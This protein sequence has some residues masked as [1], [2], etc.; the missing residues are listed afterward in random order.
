MCT[1]KSLYM[2]YCKCVFFICVHMSIYCIYLLVVKDQE[3]N[4][5]DYVQLKTQSG[6]LLSMNLLSGTGEEKRWCHQKWA[7]TAQLVSSLR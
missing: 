2:S 5:S 6:S 4:H 3:R 7:L 1:R